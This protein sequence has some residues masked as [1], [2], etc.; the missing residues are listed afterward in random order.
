LQPPGAPKIPC[1]DFFLDLPVPLRW[2][3]EERERVA[4]ISSRDPT[5]EKE[6]RNGGIKGIP[7]RD[8][9]QK[10]LIPSQFAVKSPFHA[11]VAEW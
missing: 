6:R 8:R 1:Q 5:S 11:G 3:K 7:N 2:K 9:R 10:Q 4:D